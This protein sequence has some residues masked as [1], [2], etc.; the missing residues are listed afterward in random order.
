M[1]A[2]QQARNVGVAAQRLV[3][4]A[5]QIRLDVL[6]QKPENQLAVG[7]APGGRGGAAVQAIDDLPLEFELRDSRGEIR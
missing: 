4:A 1:L 3:V 2:G 7:Q 5:G 6:R